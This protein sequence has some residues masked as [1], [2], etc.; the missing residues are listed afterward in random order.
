MDW[1]TRLQS[2]DADQVRL[3]LPE[4]PAVL[5]DT[6]DSIWR[7]TYGSAEED[8]SDYTDPAERIA[9]MNAQEN[10]V[11]NP[12]VPVEQVEELDLGGFPGAQQFP[13]LARYR[14]LKRLYIWENDWTEMPDALFDLQQLELLYIADQLERVSSRI[15]AL[16]KLR[17]LDLDGNALRDLPAEIKHL[18]NLQRLSVAINQLEAFPEVLLELPNLKELDLR[19]N[20]GLALTETQEQALR[21]KGVQCL[22][23]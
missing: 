12:L 21:E 4:T 13:E 19:G 20:E 18:S 14:S 22:V 17:E 3:A 23:D 7:M 11:P 16:P 5:L 1:L 15:A 10:L 9:L 6:L 8:H 2:T